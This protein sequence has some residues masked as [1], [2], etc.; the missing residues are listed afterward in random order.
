M[1]E[2]R[3]KKKKEG[4]GQGERGR[5]ARRIIPEQ[6]FTVFNL[7]YA[8]LLS[9]VFTV[10]YCSIPSIDHSNIQRSTLLLPVSSQYRSPLVM[11]TI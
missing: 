7:N 3:G 9:T 8:M 2:R 4:V 1:G 11:I 6:R 10:K 5:T